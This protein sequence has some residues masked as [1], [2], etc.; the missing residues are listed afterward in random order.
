MLRL[1][2]S[3]YL[4]SRE[5]KVTA[6]ALLNDTGI[7]TRTVP[8]RAAGVVS[9]FLGDLGRVNLDRFVALKRRRDDGLAVA[10]AADFHVQG[11]DIVAVGSGAAGSAA[12]KL[13]WPTGSPAAAAGSS[14]TVD[15]D[16]LGGTAQRLGAEE[17]GRGIGQLQLELQ[18]G[19]GQGAALVGEQRR[20]ADLIDLVDD[21]V[22]VFAAGVMDW[23]TGNHSCQKPAKEGL[24][25]MFTAS[26]RLRV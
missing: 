16:R 2:G 3:K 13:N 5:G 14:L 9:V 11:D 10:A 6:P 12:E 21:A 8:F 7:S 18:G 15:L 24:E 26:M 22:D 17:H 25:I 1:A 20:F 23:G 4:N 19:N